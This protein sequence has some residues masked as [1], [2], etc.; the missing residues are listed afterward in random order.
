MS[1]KFVQKRDASMQ[2]ILQVGL[3][4]FAENGYSP[5]TIRM[6][7]EKAGI[8]LGLLYNYFKSKEEVLR[9]IFQKNIRDIQADWRNSKESDQGI[10]LN[11]FIRQFFKNVKNNNH[12]WI[13]FYDL[14][15]SGT[16]ALVVTN[17]VKEI[18]SVLQKILENCLVEAEIAFPGLEAKLLLASLDGVAQHFLLQNSFPV[19]DVVHLLLMK[20]PQPNAK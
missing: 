3:D 13:L 2:L 18:E 12:F 16:T 17:E 7:A 6:I 19:N 5:T 4:L 14:R 8:S 11:R 9:A 15:L 1:T 10:T 20:Y